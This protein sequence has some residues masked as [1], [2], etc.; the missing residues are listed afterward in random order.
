MYDN[1]SSPE[2]KDWVAMRTASGDTYFADATRCSVV[3]NAS[4][5]VQ[6]H[7]AEGSITLQRGT[8]SD[9]VL[10]ALDGDERARS[11]LD[12]ESGKTSAASAKDI[13]SVSVIALGAF[14]GGCIF[15]LWIGAIGSY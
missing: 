10:A 14:I 5:R 13:A 9:V 8:K 6:L 12:P 7:T 15:G 1:P 3:V 4:G 2:R 11:I